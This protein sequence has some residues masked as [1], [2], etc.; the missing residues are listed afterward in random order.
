MTPFYKLKIYGNSVVNKFIGTILPII[1]AQFVCL[2]HVLVITFFNIKV[3]TFFFI[4][5]AIAPL[6]NYSIVQRSLFLDAQRNQKHLC[7]LVY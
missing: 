7:E 1:F 2:F 3:H 5:N 4:P 6:I